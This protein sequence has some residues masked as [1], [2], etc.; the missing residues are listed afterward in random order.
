M[1]RTPALFVGHGSPMNA[2]EDNGFTGGWRRIASLM[3]RPEAI[4][5]VSAHWYTHGTRIMDNPNPKMIYDMYGFPK[6]LYEIVYPAPGSPEFAGKAKGLLGSAATPDSGWGFDHGAWSVLYVMFPNADIPV[7][8]VSVDRRGTPESHYELGRKLAVLREEGVLILGS[9]NVVHNLA[10][11]D[12]DRED[13]FDW[14][15]EFDA[16]I[17]D[18]VM[19]RRHELAIGYGKAG[20]CARLAFP[21]PDHFHPLLAVLGASNA[22][23]DI[24]VFN[25]ACAMGSLSMTCYLFQ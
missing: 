2:I 4:L 15:Y 12:F 3:P 16:Y 9:G 24:S 21:T 8:Q 14:A 19:S 11:V 17:R 18:A 22:D 5:C 13:G 6:E 10:M 7:F 23:D 20:E 25:E 1:T